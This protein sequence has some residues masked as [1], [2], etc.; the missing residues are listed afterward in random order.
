MPHGRQRH[1]CNPMTQLPDPNNS[2]QMI[3]HQAKVTQE[4]QFHAVLQLC[5]CQHVICM[6]SIKNT[7]HKEGKVLRGPENCCLTQLEEA[8][9]LSHAGIRT[10]NN[11]YSP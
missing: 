10:K 3:L 8:V 4:F 7:K 6:Q 9:V 2:S 1:E 5:K 11:N